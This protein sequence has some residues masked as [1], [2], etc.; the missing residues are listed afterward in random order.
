MFLLFQY[1]WQGLCYFNKTERKK[2]TLNFN[3]HIRIEEIA[4]A[5]LKKFQRW[6]SN[7]YFQNVEFF[8]TSSYFGGGSSIGI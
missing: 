2:K 4:V 8:V 3:E 1:I 7:S 6:E 5:T